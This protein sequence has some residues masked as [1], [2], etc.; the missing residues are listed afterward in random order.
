MIYKH[1]T[2]Y[3]VWI[4]LYTYTSYEDVMEISHPIQQPVHSSFPITLPM[5]LQYPSP[6]PFPYSCQFQLPSLSPFPLLLLSPSPSLSSLS[7]SSASST[8]SS[9][10]LLQLPL[11]LHL[12]LCCCQLLLLLL[13][14]HHHC[15]LLITVVI[16]G[17][18]GSILTGF[19]LMLMECI[20]DFLNVSSCSHKL[21]VHLQSGSLLNGGS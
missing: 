4:E 12:P 10:A 11:L 13:H 16:A 17:A 18:V 15:L 19:L 8:P 6:S 21:I 3:S 1:C 7:A 2:N 9:T 14:H 5:S 20:A